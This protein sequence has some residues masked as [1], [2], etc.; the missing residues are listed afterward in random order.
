[1]KKIENLFWGIF[2]IVFF[3]WNVYSL[4]RFII[5][6]MPLWIVI[7]IGVIILMIW[8]SVTAF[9]NYYKDERRKN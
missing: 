8:M 6:K 5:K 9:S 3:V 2:G 4:T 7:S 1:M